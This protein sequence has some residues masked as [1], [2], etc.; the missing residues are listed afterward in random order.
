MAQNVEHVLIAA[1]NILREAG[2][3]ITLQ[4]ILITTVSCIAPVILL[5]LLAALKSPASLPSP[6]GCRKLGIRGRSNLEDQYSK[7]Y[8]KGSDPT[9]QKPWTV[10]ALFVYPLKSGAP[11]ELDKSDIDR[12]GLK[13]DRQFTLA[14]QVTSLPTLDGKVTSEW[15]FMTQRKFPRLAKVETEIWVPDPSARGYK[16]DGE[17]VKSD[18]C[19]IIRFPFSP[20]TDFTLEGLINYG[21][22]MLAKLSR[23]SEPTLEF[24]VPFNPP[25]ERIEKKG[26]RNEVLR[27]WKD[28]PVALNVS[29]EIDR[30]VFE[31]LR[32]TLGAANP[33]ALFR[34]DANAYREVHKCAPK[35]G[36]VGFETVIGMHDSYPVHILNLA[37][38][39]DVA[40]KLPNPSSDFGEIWQRHLTLLDALRF[41]ANIYIT[42]PPAFAEDNWKKAKLTS[43]GSTSSLDMHISC[44]TTRC[45]L[46]NVD[47]KTAIADKNEPL[48]TLRSYR[49]IDQG[50]KNACLGMQ[51]TPLNMGTVAVGDKIEVLETGE[52]F[53]DGGEGKKVDG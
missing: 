49:I 12:T 36:D 18:G 48:T 22:I 46:P 23:Q 21:R 3:N 8:A 39:H 38:V 47:P 27:I 29:S 7:R 24:R 5:L 15:H 17:W 10:K 34:I 19:L 2:I 43:S 1:N 45:K 42:G 9:P 4:T 26:Y 28:S 53:F 11:V 25:Q 16:E 6:A 51:V 33:I 20:D 35:K 13:Y 32:Y 40:S 41:R 50:S 30:E 31:K 52:H 14:Q 44:R 37:S